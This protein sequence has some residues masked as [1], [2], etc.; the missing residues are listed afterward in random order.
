M[1]TRT[2]LA[3]TVLTATSTGVEPIVS[4]AEARDAYA[5][6]IIAM[7]PAEITALSA[8]LRLSRLVMPVAP[9]DAVMVLDGCGDVPQINRVALIHDLVERNEG[10]VWAA[11]FR[12]ELE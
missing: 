6:S 12:A 7:V 5:G 10:V 4:A 1:V 3:L 2:V 8:P 11:T 9:T